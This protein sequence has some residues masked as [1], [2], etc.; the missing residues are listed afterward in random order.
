MRGVLILIIL[1]PRTFQYEGV[2]Q[3]VVLHY[4]FTWSEYG[5]N[6]GQFFSGV[7]ENKNLGQ[8]ND[9]KYIT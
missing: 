5:Q 9:R 4:Q 6:I 1:F 3:N 8:S 2:T 7:W